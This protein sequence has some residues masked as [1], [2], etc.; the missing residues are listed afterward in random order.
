MRNRSVWREGW[1]VQRRYV[2]PHRRGAAAPRISARAIVAAFA[3]VLL[4][5]P[6]VALAGD[7]IPSTATSVAGSAVLASDPS[8]DPAAPACESAPDRVLVRYAANAGHE[9]RANATAKI[10]GKRLKT[11]RLTPGIELVRTS[12]S[13]ARAS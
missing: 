5:A 13:P 6:S 12:L 7:P 1:A 10:K 11:W 2:N 9:A 4:V 8:G 3:A